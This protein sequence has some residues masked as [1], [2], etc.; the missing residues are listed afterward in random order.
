MNNPLDQEGKWRQDPGALKSGKVRVRR[1]LPRKNTAAAERNKGSNSN[2]MVLQ[3]FRPTS[4]PNLGSN[5]NTSVYPIW[6]VLCL[7]ACLPAYPPSFP[8]G[9]QWRHRTARHGRLHTRPC[10]A[11]SPSPPLG[12]RRL[13]LPLPGST[14]KLTNCAS[15]AQ[16]R[17]RARK[18]PPTA[19][20]FSSRPSLG[21]SARF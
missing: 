13:N 10:T 5:P 3:K 12:L 1:N 9:V 11:R 14:L 16:A 17:A 7:P 20:V 19:C 6:P 21:A 4:Q 2:E 18:P 15:Q 8:L